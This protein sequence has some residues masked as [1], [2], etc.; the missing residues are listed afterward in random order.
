MSE[1]NNLQRWR[2]R[3]RVIPAAA[4][5]MRRPRAHAALNVAVK[6]RL[7]D[8]TV[9]KSGNCGPRGQDPV[10]ERGGSGGFAEG[11]SGAEDGV[12]DGEELA[13]DGHH[14]DLSRLPAAFILA[15]KSARKPGWSM[16]LVAAM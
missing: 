4:C 14:D 2:V 6:G 12:G 10:V 3:R 15:M 7:P 8:L 11:L 5:F 13:G 1:G 9:G 16:V